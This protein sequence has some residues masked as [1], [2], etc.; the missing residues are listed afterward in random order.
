MEETREFGVAV[1]NDEGIISAFQEKPKP[2]EALSNLS[3]HRNLR[4]SSQGSGLHSGKYVLRP[5]ARRA[6]RLARSGR[7]ARRGSERRVLDGRRESDCLQE[8]PARQSSMDASSQSCP[9]GRTREGDVVLCAGSD[10]RGKVEGYSVIGAGAVV[11]AGAIVRDS[12]LWDGAVSEGPEPTWK[13]GSS[14]RA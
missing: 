11:E 5:R 7:A 6:S 13:M 10:V 3:Q 12:I 14:A 2:E 1:V 9:S 4:F 8:S